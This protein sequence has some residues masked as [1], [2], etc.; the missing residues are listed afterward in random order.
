V[1]RRLVVSLVAT[2]VAAC[3]ALAAVLITGTSPQLGLDL[4]GGAAVVLRPERKVPKAVLNQSIKIIRS[5]V[6]ALGVAEPEI[7]SQG[8]NIVVEL[9]GVKDS[10][11]ALDVVGQTAELRFR[12]VLAPNA[13]A[14]PDGEAKITTRGEEPLRAGAVGAHRPSRQGRPGRDPARL[15]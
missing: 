15:G 8:E 10:S 14:G 7:S 9:P 2:L 11:R 3:G 1:K 4:Q 13:P 5:R 12:P 6:D